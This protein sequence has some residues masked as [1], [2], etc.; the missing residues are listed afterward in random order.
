MSKERGNEKRTVI[1]ERDGE[2]TIRQTETV[3]TEGTEVCIRW[4][5]CILFVILIVF[6]FL[7]IGR[8]SKIR[9]SIDTSERPTTQGQSF[10]VAEDVSVDTGM[11]FPDSSKVLLT[12]DDIDKCDNKDRY[13]ELEIIQHAINELY[14]RKGYHFTDPEW[15]AYYS[16]YP[17]YVDRGLT[18]EETVEK[19]NKIELQNMKFLVEN[20][21]RIRGY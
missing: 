5:W 20:R 13:S 9:E 12:Y 11:M 19:F 14:A 16:N 8:G 17:W 4:R 10:V 3:V 15:Y 6:F 7:I 2:V 18:G 1:V 21:K